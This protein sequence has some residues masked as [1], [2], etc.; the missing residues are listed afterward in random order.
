MNKDSDI[1]PGGASFILAASLVGALA[2][3]RWLGMILL[4][5]QTTCCAAFD[6]AVGAAAFILTALHAL[7]M[8]VWGPGG[9]QART[10]FAVALVLGAAS[11]AL[12]WTRSVGKRHRRVRI[13]L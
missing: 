1:G 4:F 5:L 12:V 8:E 3:G 9:W 13:P 10:L 7:L 2:G 11:V 6:L